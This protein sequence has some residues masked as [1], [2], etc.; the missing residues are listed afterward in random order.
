MGATLG[1]EEAHI[2]QSFSGLV[3]VLFR[4]AQ[5]FQELLFK[6]VSLKIKQMS[7]QSPN[8]FKQLSNYFKPNHKSPVENLHPKICK[9]VPH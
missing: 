8:Y 9:N 6:L 7:K 2:H 3:S 1:T 4:T 5:L